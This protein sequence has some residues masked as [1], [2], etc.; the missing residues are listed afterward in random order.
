MRVRCLHMNDAHIYCTKEQ[1][2]DEF[3]AVNDMYLKYFKIFGIDKY[4]MRLS[5]AFSGQTRQK[6]VNEPELWKETED[7]VRNVLIRIKYS[8]CGSAG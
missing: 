7:M 3:R 8:F 5:L 6:Y 2:N 1:F 4:V